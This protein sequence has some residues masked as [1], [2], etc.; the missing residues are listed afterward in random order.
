MTFSSVLRR[1]LAAYRGHFRALMMTLLLE[2]VL[3]LIALT[4]LLFLAA[5]QTRPLALICIPLYLLIVLPARQ[6]VALALQDLLSG[7]SPFS[8][9][10]VS[11][12]GYGHKLLRGLISVGKLLLW[13]APLIVGVALA[14]WA[15]SGGGSFD[16]FTLLRTIRSFGGDDLFRGMAYLAAIYL[17]TLIPLLI[18]CAF[19]SGD[20]HA[21]ALG[22]PRL[23]KGRRGALI[24]YWF[25]GLIVFVPFLAV[26][27]FPCASLIRALMG[28]INEFFNTFEFTFPAV[29]PQL[30]MLGTAVVILLLPAIPL[31]A[32]MPAT[33]LRDA[34]DRAA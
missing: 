15:W 9:R 6:N 27:A 1:A 19:H 26:A 16:G 12:E 33:C 23:P 4:P 31:R 30:A 13:G 21:V 3:R 20:R 2:L 34:A 24:R 25:A 5:P 32:L 7:G 14:R 10:L 18:G 11:L 29:G 22:N 28:A 17:A 8:L